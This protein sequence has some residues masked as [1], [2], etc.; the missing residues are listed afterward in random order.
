MG[1]FDHWKDEEDYD[2]SYRE[3]TGIGINFDSNADALKEI[4]KR[5]DSDSWLSDHERSK[6]YELKERIENS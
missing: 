2:Q 4:Q 3:I 6:L 5:L 1:L